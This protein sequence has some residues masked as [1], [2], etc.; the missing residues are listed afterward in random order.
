MANTRM[1][2]H[3]HTNT[4]HVQTQALLFR[5]GDGG[6]ALPPDP[7]GFQAYLQ[8]AEALGDPEA[9]FCL[10]DMHLHGEYLYIH[11]CV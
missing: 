8:K 6:L 2:Q 9:L 11:M 7:K 10:A 1:H 5:N 4:Y 3:T